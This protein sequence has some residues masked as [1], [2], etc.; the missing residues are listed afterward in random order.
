MS[1][2]NKDL[3]AKL[4]QTDLEKKYQDKKAEYEILVEDRKR[5]E[6]LVES[7][8]QQRDLYRALLNKHDTNL[9]GGGDE[10]SALAIVKGQS[11]RTKALQVKHNQ[12]TKEHGEALAKLDVM[13]RDQEA[14]SERLARY[15]MLNDEL[16]KSI[17]KANLEISKGKAAVAR[18][19]AEAVF[20]KDKAQMLE[21]AQQRYREEI[22]NVTTSKNR[23]MILNT[24]LEQSISKANKSS[25]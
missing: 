24:D 17:D 3:K 5:Q 22:K 19:E 11:E 18:S 4:D 23:I 12:L 7:I 25:G 6:I 2:E 8:A 13:A 14:A 21:D 15:E 1:E 9:L 10:T 16:T 20:F